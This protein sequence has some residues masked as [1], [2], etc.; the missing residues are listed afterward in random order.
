M[1]IGTLRHQNLEGGTC[2]VAAAL[3]TVKPTYEC[4]STNVINH[5]RSGREAS[6]ARGAPSGAAIRL[7]GYGFKITMSTRRL[8]ARPSAVSLLATGW[9]SANIAAANRCGSKPYCSMNALI[10]PEAP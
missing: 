1:R 7:D 2:S 3:K 10:S 5:Q 8:R 6:R 9:H 4:Y